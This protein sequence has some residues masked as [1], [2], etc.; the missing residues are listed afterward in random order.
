MENASKAL[1]IA[2]AILLAILIIGLGVF[3]YNQASNT[4]SDT[5]MDQVAIRQF[6]GQFEPYLNREI[7][8]MQAKALIDTI[9]QSNRTSE[10]NVLMPGISNK[11]QIQTG[12]KY[13]VEVS[14]P[15]GVINEIIIT[16]TN[17][18]IS[19][20]GGDNNGN[21]DA[22]AF[23]NRFFD[24]LVPTTRPGQSYNTLELSLEESERLE[25]SA[26]DASRIRSVELEYMNSRP[27]NVEGLNV[28]RVGF[29]DEGYICHINVEWREDTTVVQEHNITESTKMFNQRFN[30]Y[31]AVILSESR[32]EN[33]EQVVQTVNNLDGPN[34][35]T[36]VNQEETIPEDAIIDYY[37]YFIGSRYSD[38]KYKSFNKRIVYHQP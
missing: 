11:S 36:I 21:A 18:S 32:M 14:Q 27:K 7:G 29:D 22:L 37:I 19:S 34:T 25:I 17:G 24:G 13:N 20:G 2:G 6:N 16:D 28:I 26:R 12:H 31:I 3:I 15:N 30:D 8:A 10:I 9:D 23:N 5:G 4:I 33:F 1:I 35:I 38:D